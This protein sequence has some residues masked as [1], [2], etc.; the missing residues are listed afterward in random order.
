MERLELEH[1]L[2]GVAEVL[3]GAGNLALLHAILG[4]R[5]GL[6]LPRR[7]ADVRLDL[8]ALGTG[9]VLVDVLG[10]DVA[11]LALPARR[12]VV[13]EVDDLQAAG[14][15]GREGVPLL[16]EDWGQLQPPSDSRMSF[17]VTLA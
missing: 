12:R 17:S 2:G 13:E 9:E 4:A 1:L 14:V 8:V 10:G 15:L 6:V 5:D 16:A 11:V 7:A 3:E